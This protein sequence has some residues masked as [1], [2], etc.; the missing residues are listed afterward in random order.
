MTQNTDDE[1]KLVYERLIAL[2]SRR[3]HSQF[4]LQQKLMVKRCSP[5]IVEAQIE[6]VKSLGFQSDERYAEVA[7]RDLI[8]KGKG[9]LYVSGYLKQRK[10]SS[11]HIHSAIAVSDVDWF[12]LALEVRRKRFSS[13][14]LKEH[15]IKQKCY[16]YLAQRGFD[17]E[18]VQ[19]A[20]N[21]DDE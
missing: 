18:Q 8:R 1:T 12:E 10:V 2:L 14:Q 21:A 13:E 19:Y 5:A 9:P 17:S 7:V 20:I 11:Q 4:E 16:R 6:R 3:E 15:P